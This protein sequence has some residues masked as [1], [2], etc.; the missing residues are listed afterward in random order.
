MQSQWQSGGAR[1]SNR[2]TTSYRSGRETDTAISVT[3]MMC[4]N[5]N[6]AST[7]IVPQTNRRAGGRKQGWR[8]RI[9]SAFKVSVSMPVMGEKLGGPSLTAEFKLVRQVQA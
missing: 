1:Y 2:N 9:G 4:L 8:Y 3:E 5:S 7:T 6:T